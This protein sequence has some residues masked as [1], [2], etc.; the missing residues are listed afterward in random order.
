MSD[1]TFDEAVRILRSY[2]I[3]WGYRTEY[4]RGVAVSS[5]LLPV[6]YEKRGHYHYLGGRRVSRNAASAVLRV[7]LAK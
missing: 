5:R 6:A 2:R 1:R 7:G 3:V 4:D